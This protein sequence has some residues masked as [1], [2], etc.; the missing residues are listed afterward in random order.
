[1]L[2]H[3]R[4]LLWLGSA[5]RY[6]QMKTDLSIQNKD[7]MTEVKNINT[8]IDNLAESVHDLK[9]EN[10]QL[11]QSNAELQSQLNSV[12]RRRVRLCRGTVSSK[13]ASL[14]RVNGI[15]GRVDEHW[16]VTEQMVRSFIK[17]EMAM[18]GHESV[19]VERAHRLKSSDRFTKF[20]DREA[21]L[22]KASDIFD[23]ESPFSVQADYT[24]RVKKHRRELGKEMIAAR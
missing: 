18:P 21:I 16:D 22:R 15:H 7:V 14:L 1:M 20:K 13:Q 2:F 5:V 12:A 10:E 3:R 11:K 4:G 23:H 24:Q 9:T 6:T 19:E 17:N 8:K